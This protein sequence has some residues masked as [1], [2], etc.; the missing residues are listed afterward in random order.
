QVAVPSILRNG[1]R[2]GRDRRG[3]LEREGDGGTVRGRGRRERA[4]APVRESPSGLRR[5]TGGRGRRRAPHPARQ[6]REEARRDRQDR[7][8]SNRGPGHRGPWKPGRRRRRSPREEAHPTTDRIDPTEAGADRGGTGMKRIPTKM[9]G[10]DDVLGGG[11]P[12]GSIVLVS[13]APGTMK[14]SLTYH[15]LH[16]NALDRVRGL[17]VSLAKPREPRRSHGGTRVSPRRYRREP[18]H[19]GPGDV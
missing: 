10:L 1:R 18:E 11:I 6:D 14:T 12:D 2:T 3:L 5:A 8:R 17:Y 7:P 16:A 19:L 13:G 4:R 9:E 15:I